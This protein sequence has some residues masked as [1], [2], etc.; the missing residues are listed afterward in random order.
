[1][2]TKVIISLFEDL[3]TLKSNMHLNFIPSITLSDIP[4]TF[5]FKS[6]VL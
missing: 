1:M 6:F 5:D 2:L 4:A 3:S